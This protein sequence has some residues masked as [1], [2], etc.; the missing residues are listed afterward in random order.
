M[1]PVSTEAAVGTTIRRRK[2]AG[3]TIQSLETSGVPRG[4]LGVLEALQFEGARTSRLHGLGVDE[5]Q[6]LL[7]WCDRRQLTLMLPE[8][9]GDAL[10]IWVQERISGT[11]VDFEKR[12]LD[13]KADLF[14]IAR[15]LG[16]R[17]LEFVVLKGITHAPTLTPS[18]L[19]RAQGDIDLWLNGESVYD[20]QDALIALG[21][22]STSSGGPRHLAPFVRPIEWQWRGNLA[23][24]PVGI[25]LHHTLWSRNAEYINISGQHEFWER[26]ETRFFDG[27]ALD[28]L[29]REDLLAFAAVHL[30]LHLIHGDLPLQ[31]SWEI[32]NFL[33]Y[34]AN[35]EPFWNNWK[36]LQPPDLRQIQT[37][38]FAIV[39]EWFA[40]RLPECVE[41]AEL[42]L[43]DNVRLWLDRFAL[44][45]LKSQFRP[46]K[47]DLWLHLA[48]IDS[49]R[50]K[51]QCSHGDWSR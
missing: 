7:S 11:T 3:A 32:A 51:V 40:C 17:G 33:H 37:V 12:L 5:W 34:S 30:F 44:S 42:H 48:L 1:D 14:E 39:N 9:C 26:R 29:R 28:V 25:E 36:Q 47:D 19:W 46:N 43:P 18:A 41:E 10:P 49:F 50:E 15:S 35:D 31:R 21:Y 16:G 27:H 22:V 8:Y 13:L 6:M 2:R 20:A 24:V 38:V 4:I 45:P 23:E